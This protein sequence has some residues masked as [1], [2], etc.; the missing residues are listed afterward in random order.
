M[1]SAFVYTVPINITVTAPAGPSLTGPTQETWV[2]LQGSSLVP[3]DTHTVTLTNGGGSTAYVKTVTVTGDFDVAG[4]ATG[5]TVDPSGGTAT[6]TVTP[7]AS[8]L[9]TINTYTGSV[10]IVY[11]D[12]A[13][14][15]DK[16]LT[17]GLRAEVKNATLPKIVSAETSGSFTMGGT[18]NLTKLLT[19][20]STAIQG[21]FNGVTTIDWYKGDPANGGTLVGTT[22]KTTSI[23]FL[24]SGGWAIGDEVYI[25]VMGDGT[26]YDAAPVDIKVGTIEQ[27]AVDKYTIVVQKTDTNGVAINDNAITAVAAPT[28]LGPNDTANLFTN[29]TDPGYKFVKWVIAN[30]GAGTLTNATTANSATYKAPATTGTATITIQAQYSLMPVLEVK[31]DVPTT[32]GS[33][34]SG[35]AT[36]TGKGSAT[37][38]TGTLK[39]AATDSGHAANFEVTVGGAASTTIAAGSIGNTAK[40]EVKVKSGVTLVPGQTYDMVLTVVDDEGDK[41]E[42]NVTYTAPYPKWTITLKHNEHGTL[43][44]NFG[45]VSVATVITGSADA[46]LNNVSHGGTVAIE[47]APAPGYKFAGWTSSVTAGAGTPATDAFGD[48]TKAATSYAN[49]TQAAT[50]TATFKPVTDLSLDPT[51]GVGTLAEGYTS[52]SAIYTGTVTNA[53]AKASDV[54]YALFK[55]AGCTQADTSNNFVL[56]SAS[57]TIAAAGTNPGTGT[58]TVTPKASGLTAGTYKTYL[59]IKQGEAVGDTMSGVKTFVVPITLYVTTSS[60]F[61]GTVTVKVDDTVKNGVA[62][63]KLTADGATIAPVTVSATGVASFAGLDINKSY[64]VAV[65]LDGIDANYKD[66]GKTVSNGA[67]TATV[68]YYTLTLSAGTG[69]KAVSYAANPTTSDSTLTKVV[70]KGTAVP[71]YAAASAGYDPSSLAWT[72]TKTTGSGAVASTELNSMVT[73]K[74]AVTATADYTVGNGVKYMMNAGDATAV[75]VTDNAYYGASAN[76]TLPAKPSR[77]GYT[78]KGWATTAAGTAIANSATATTLSTANM[79]AAASGFYTLYAVWE[80]ATA[81]WNTLGSGV[82]GAEYTGSASIVNGAAV[83]AVAY[84]VSTGTD[85]TGLPDG[86]TFTAATGAIAGTPK[87]T[88]TFTFTVTATSTVNSSD[89]WEKADYE[90]VVAKATPTVT[91]LS[92]AGVDEGVA[93]ADVTVYATVTAPYWNPTGGT[94]TGAWET[95]KQYVYSAS[96]DPTLNPGAL[97]VESP[98]TLNFAGAT[99]LAGTVKFTAATGT[100]TALMGTHQ[101]AQKF[102]D[103]YGDVTVPCVFSLAGKTYGITVDPASKSADINVNAAMP[104][105]PWAFKVTNMG[106]QK[107]YVTYKLDNSADAAKFTLTPGYSNTNHDQIN[108]A[109]A[110]GGTEMA[111]AFTLLPVAYNASSAPNGI[112]PAVPGVYTVNVI[113]ENHEWDTADGG[114]LG[115]VQSTVTVPVRFE[116]KAPDYVG[117]ITTHLNNVDGSTTANGQVPG[118]NSLTLTEVGGTATVSAAWDGTSYKTA[119]DALTGGKSYTVAIGGYVVPGVYLSNANPSAT[120]E[121]YEVKLVNA[122]AANTGTVTL[123]GPGY[124][125]A[126]QT[127]TVSAPA[128]ATNATTSKNYDFVDWKKDA[129]TTNAHTTYREFSYQMPATGATDPAPAAVTFTAAYKERSALTVKVTYEDN[130]PDGVILVP[131]TKDDVAKGGTT[132]LAATAPVRPGYDF[133]G[134]STAADA[135]KADFNPDTHTNP[136]TGAGNRYDALPGATTPALDNDVTL[137]A[138]WEKQTA[139]WPDAALANGV[140]GSQYGASVAVTGGLNVNV[141]YALKMGSGDLP[142]GLKLSSDGVI[143][144]KPYEV[145]ANRSFTVV[146]TQTGLIT[147]VDGASTTNTWEKEFTITVEQAQPHLS[148]IAT[149]GTAVTGAAYSTITY[150]ADVVAPI[151]QTKESDPTVPADVWETR[152]VATVKAAPLP[153]DTTAAADGGVL[154]VDTPNSTFVGT[155]INPVPLTWTPGAS[156]GAYPLNDAHGNNFGTIYKAA[157]DTA[158]VSTNGDAYAMTVDPVSHSWTVEVGYANGSYTASGDGNPVH[159]GDVDGNTAYGKQFTLTNTGNQPTGALQYKFGTAGSSNAAGKYFAMDL[160]WVTNN[161]SLPVNA[162]TV[163]NTDHQRKFSVQPRVYT[164]DDALTPG[165]YT[166]TLTISSANG[167]SAVVYSLTLVVKE[168]STFDM[169]VDTKLHTADDR[170]GA[171]GDVTSIALRAV[172]TTDDT[173]PDTD[174]AHAANSGKYAWTGLDSTKTYAVVV[175]GYVSNQIVTAATTGP[176][177]VDL[178]QMTLAQAP[179]GAGSTLKL[180]DVAVTSGY[181]LAGQPLKASATVPTGKS[182]EDWDLSV[183]SDATGSVDTEGYSTSKALTYVMPAAPAKLTANFTDVVEYE[184]QVVDADGTVTYFN[185]GTAE[186]YLDILTGGTVKDGT[187]YMVSEGAAFGL[188]QPT[189]GTLATGQYSVTKVGYTFRGWSTDAAA[190]TGAYVFTA[191]AAADTA[192]GNTADKVIQ[193]YPVWTADSDLAFTGGTVTG[194]Y[195]HALTNQKVTPATGGSAPYAYDWND[196]TTDGTTYRPFGVTMNAAGDFASTADATPNGVGS[197]TV[198]IKAADAAGDTA[199]ADYVFIISKAEMEPDATHGLP[200]AAVA[201]TMGDTLDTVKTAILGAITAASTVMNGDGTGETAING[202]WTVDPAWVLPTE[203]GTYDVPVIYTPAND[204]VGDHAHDGDNYNPYHGTVKVTLA[205]KAITGVDMQVNTPQT[206]GTPDSLSTVVTAMG[207][208]TNHVTSSDN[209]AKWQT[210]LEVKAVRWAPTVATTFE[211]NTRYTVTVDLAIKDGSKYRFDTSTVTGGAY[212]FTAQVNGQTATL[213]SINANTVSLSYEFPAEAKAIQ[214][215]DVTVGTLGEGGTDTDVASAKPSQ[216]TVTGHKWYDSDGTLVSNDNKFNTS[217]TYDLVVTVK[218]EEGYQ[219]DATRFGGIVSTELKDGATWYATVN[220]VSSGTDPAPKTAKVEVALT[221]D[222]VLQIRYSAFTPVAETPLSI[223]SVTGSVGAYYAMTGADAASHKHYDA[224]A[225]GNKSGVG[226]TFNPAGVTVKVTFQKADGSTS[227]KQV[228]VGDCAFYAGDPDVSG[229]TAVKLIDKTTAAHVFKNFG[230]DTDVEKYDGQMVY[231]KYGTLPA[232]QV[233]T[234]SVRALEVMSIDKGTD[235]MPKL[236]YK[237]GDHFDPATTHTAPAKVSFNTNLPAL[238]NQN[239]ELSDNYAVKDTTDN[240]PLNYY[241]ATGADGSGEL[242][243][244]TVLAAGDNGKTVYLCYTDVNDNTV[245]VSVGTLKVKA[246]FAVTVEDANKGDPEYNDTLTAVPGTGIPDDYNYRWEKWNPTGGTGGSGAWEPITGATGQTYVPGKTDIGKV[247]RVTATDKTTGTSYSSATD[248]TDGLTIMARS[249]NFKV[250]AKDKVVDGDA[251]NKYTYLATD[252]TLTNVPAA[253]PNPAFGGIV[254][255]DV[256]S[257]APSATGWNTADAT[258]PDYGAATVG[259][260]ITWPAVAV[261][262]GTTANKTGGYTLT[263]T[264]KD[265]YRLAAQ[266]AQ[267]NVGEILAKDIINV[268]HVDVSFKAIP[269]TGA[270]IPGSPMGVTDLRE[271]QDGDPTPGA[272][273]NPT[274]FKAYWYE[275]AFNVDSIASYTPATGTFGPGKTYTVAVYVKPQTGYAYKYDVSASPAADRTQFNFHFGEDQHVDATN[276]VKKVDPAGYYIMYHTFTTPTANPAVSLGGITKLTTQLYYGSTSGKHDADKRVAGTIPGDQATVPFNFSTAGLAGTVTLADGSTKTLNLAATDDH[277]DGTLEYSTDWSLV[278]G[279]SAATATQALANGF[280]FTAADMAKYDGKKV[281]VKVGDVVLDTLTTGGDASVGTLA[282]KEL[283]AESITPVYEA[284]KGANDVLKYTAGSGFNASAI[285]DATV[286]FNQGTTGLSGT[287]TAAEQANAAD[288]AGAKYYFEVNAGTA[289]KNGDQ[290]GGTTGTPVAKDGDVLYLCYTD[291]NGHEV[292]IA[293]GTIRTTDATTASVTIMNVTTTVGNATT[294]SYGDQLQAV[295]GGSTTGK[296]SY[297]WQ[298]W[299]AGNNKWVDIPN[300]NGN[301]YTAGKDDVD[302]AAALDK[303][304]RVV[305]TEAGKEGSAASSNDALTAG[306]PAAQTTSGVDVTP[307]ALTVT[308][309]ADDKVYDGTTAATI[310]QGNLVGV[311]SGDT[312]SIDTAEGK[313]VTGTFTQKGSEGAEGVAAGKTVT[314]TTATLTGADKDYYKLTVPANPTADITA[315][316][317][318]WGDLAFN[319]GTEKRYDAT[320]DVYTKDNAGNADNLNNPSGNAKVAAGQ[321]INATAGTTDAVEWASG[322]ALTAAQKTALESS[323]LKFNFAYASKNA[324]GDEASKILVKAVSTGVSTANFDLSALASDDTIYGCTVNP[325]QFNVA[326]ADLKTPTATKDGSPYVTIDSNELAPSDARIENGEASGFKFKFTVQGEFASTAASGSAAVTVTGVSAGSS[327]GITWTDRNYEPLWDGNNAT[328]GTVTGG[329]VTKVALDGTPSVIYGDAYSTAT[330]LK[331]NV[332]YDGASEVGTTL[333]SFDALVNLGVKAVV[334]HNTAHTGTAYAFVT[335]SRLA[336]WM[337]D[338]AASGDT[339][340]LKFYKMTGADDA[341]DAATAWT[342][343]TIG[344]GDTTDDA[345]KGK[346]LAV[347][348]ITVKPRELVAVPVWNLAANSNTGKYYDGTANALG[349]VWDVEADSKTATGSISF[350][351]DTILNSDAVNV[352]SGY[353]ATFADKNAGENKTITIGNTPVLE[354]AQ[355]KRYILTM[356][357]ATGSI[358]PRPITVAFDAP[359]VPLDSMDAAASKTVNLSKTFDPTVTGVTDESIAVSATGTYDTVATP[360]VAGAGDNTAADGVGNVAVTAPIWKNANYNVTVQT[361]INGSVTAKSIANVAITYNQPVK[362]GKTTDDGTSNTTNYKTPVTFSNAAQVDVTATA[363]HT[364]ASLTDLSTATAVTNDAFTAGGYYMVT[365]TVTAKAGYNFASD[366]AFTV[367]DATKTLGT[368]DGVAPTNM[369]VSVSSDKLTA[370]VKYIFAVPADSK[371]IAHVVADIPLPTVGNTV[372]SSKTS[373]TTSILTDENLSVPAATALAVEDP[374]ITWNV[375]GNDNTWG[376]VTSDKFESGKAY[377]AVLTYTVNTGD[378]YTFASAADFI[379]KGVGPALGGGSVGTAGTPVTVNGVTVTAKETTD[380]QAYVLTVEFP[381]T[382]S[383]NVTNVIINTAPLPPVAGEI[384]PTPYVVGSE[385]YQDS[386]ST[387]KWQKSSDNISWS[388]LPVGETEFKANTYYQIVG[389]VKLK[390]GEVDNYDITSATKFFIGTLGS[391][392]IG[393]NADTLSALETNGYG[394]K[395]EHIAGT[396]LDGV[397]SDDSTYTLTLRYNKLEDNTDK[398]IVKIAANVA[399]PTSNDQ[400]PNDANADKAVLLLAQNKDGLD[401]TAGVKK[402]DIEW[403]LGTEPGDA[404]GAAAASTSSDFTGWTWTKLNVGADFEPGKTYKVKFNVSADTD[405]GYKLLADESSDK[406]VEYLINSILN[407]SNQWFNGEDMGKLGRITAATAVPAASADDKQSYDV[408]VYFENVQ[409]SADVFSVWGKVTEP[410]NGVTAAD[411]QIN[412]IN[413]EEPYTL[414]SGSNKWYNDADCTDATTGTFE[415]GKTYYATLQ[416]KAKNHYQFLHGDEG[417]DTKGYTNDTAAGATTVTYVQGAGTETNPEFIT[418]VRPFTVP[419]IPVNVRVSSTVPTDGAEVAT[420]NA[421]VKAPTGVTEYAVSAGKWYN[422][423]GTTEATSFEAGKTYKLIAK[424]APTDD[425][426]ALNADRGG[427]S[428]DEGYRIANTVESSTPAGVYITT[429]EYT[430]PSAGKVVPSTYVKAPAKGQKGTEAVGTNVEIVDTTWSGNGQTNVQPDAITFQDGKTYTVNVTIKGED[431][432]G[433]PISAGSVVQINGRDVTITSGMSDG[434]GNWIITDSWSLPKEGDIINGGSGGGGGGGGGGSSSEIVVT[435]WL[436]ETGVTKDLTAEAVKKNKYPTNVPSVTG[437]S[438]YKFLGW[439]ETDPAK[440]SGKPK[441]VDPTSFKI[442]GDKT[443]YAVYETEAGHT[444]IDHGH[445]VIGYPNGTF[446]PS[447]DITRGSVATIIARACLEGFVEGSDYGNPGNYSDV[448]NDWAYS[449]ISFC[450]INGVFKGYDDGTFR[451]GQPITRQEFAT[452]IARLA[453]IQSNQGMP[454]SDAGDIASW[455]VDGVYTTYANGWVNGYTDGTFKPL[456]NIH[457]DEAVKIFNGYLNRGVDAAG[458]SGLTEYV[459]SGVASHN[460]EDGSTQY[461]TWPDVPKGH[462][463]YYE[464]IE[465]A[466]DHT[467]YWPDETKPVP[468]EHWMNVWINEVW[469]YHDNASDG[470][471]TA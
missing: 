410:R 395:F 322:S 379:I 403:Y 425:K 139:A 408:S 121:M 362:G 262:A 51:S 230:T 387:I 266:G 84:A 96:G 17:I 104:T 187:K 249:L 95:A 13:T 129:E 427:Y 302:T 107:A 233:G 40:V 342:K 20:T 114:K 323:G 336:D 344:A 350:S 335:G 132:Q 397:Y 315:L 257:M 207:N 144:G 371:V 246:T 307:K 215:I 181:Y 213:N 128:D 284:G 206:G 200:T 340:N 89:T 115:G 50:L 448:A 368:A 439:S 53:G 125:A 202:G 21:A 218:P 44:A 55:D 239:V 380:N 154:A 434:H 112:N 117:A 346:N 384:I 317:L 365:A 63:V 300:A 414:V 343:S 375:K 87:E 253:A 165:V 430:I 183:Y 391:V 264:D 328:T 361:P 194:V 178:Y 157:K 238:S 306:T 254:P 217:K 2:K 419:K 168:A 42:L 99:T 363:W 369:S 429:F 456:S 424:A 383:Q 370:T 296:L 69:A 134:W 447:D 232:T 268:S 313:K 435:Y 466:N 345:T 60:T 119:A 203:P 186:S 123:T 255:G 292:R 58:V 407:N 4:I 241:F 91:A 3:G 224:A 22:G 196:K 273:G 174:P 210:D 66:T 386:G 464:I 303:N 86:L 469:R 251:L 7:K 133:V 195:K 405:N 399:Q 440:T 141:T 357:T 329:A 43:S 1:A 48:D 41:V 197:K 327:A 73:V 404:T 398:T 160:G 396:L 36:N 252:F 269:V 382:G 171:L 5:A 35:T 135:T 314:L 59:Q 312:V 243:A 85:Q 52:P 320:T 190:A 199:V 242:T 16:T 348:T 65:S 319:V 275:G 423:D 360:I 454:F 173:L 308:Y 441:L 88:G 325:K 289:I 236:E 208:G 32:T 274:T 34:W 389:T 209:A 108:P 151:L 122:S 70:L 45:G 281:F 153:A 159:D 49:V 101:S 278:V 214:V 374:V 54:T 450:T 81:T 373:A 460:T 75:Y 445:Y 390:N 235:N 152:V 287:Y 33:A 68:D 184:V 457:R 24:S 146:A 415:A 10:K 351:Y 420:I 116:V 8:I 290:I 170:A 150:T 229:S 109:T 366:A 166:D 444:A 38:V 138:V 334:E 227:I 19:D 418:L 413:D 295:V 324:L 78:F 277:D 468:P 57:A 127:G 156:T 179:A 176:V 436:G 392:E 26:A 231:V 417:F 449:A 9:S 378:G 332:Y 28:A 400:V 177:V 137:Y 276:T 310:H 286:S 120:V 443:F 113:V 163:G 100:A 149:S 416:V 271:T 23:S 261:D 188:P 67:K 294:A 90:I 331:I 259:S 39:D 354:G 426:Y 283:T 299:D 145:A 301:F 367:N 198:K 337:N 106:N 248:G 98:S 240:T 377:Q 124:L 97:T 225:T 102:S 326:V 279:D 438:G 167:A 30:S 333:T 80:K 455:A 446:G 162:N 76:V 25:R 381:K 83:G 103:I 318:T 280:T 388:D 31:K 46:T 47:A 147:A 142:G 155:G 285:T 212:A 94:G 189:T 37:N 462:W 372:N 247:I 356:E 140:Y 14:G 305:V 311:I 270:A 143:T 355:A 459:H 393:Q 353:T 433:N 358:K 79:G 193:L 82:Y 172:G 148:N 221:A 338:A 29:T 131:P 470:G 267:A 288:A 432:T 164:G 442:T 222:G 6:F 341:T 180:D 192:D 352:K 304:L 256:V 245:S 228:A 359:T 411:N 219:F 216:Y 258:R 437:I 223:A 394:V 64:A 77:S 185:G 458:L 309:T 244:A 467:F 297:Q 18:V 316:K 61:T 451:P 105:T 136:A 347:G 191:N 92:F 265:C 321:T 298:R 471:P 250:A 110:S 15:G 161:N 422:A 385:P 111:D 62:K 12:G 263:G 182:L 130:Y 401:M 27:P 421:S 260:A 126:G 72:L 169:E 272:D 428:W 291:V 282:V 461:M 376:A 11:N 93:K 226:F 402:K 453:G 118:V 452:V 74:E 158:N 406:F 293:I 237:V 339:L 409:E 234:L 71:V 204:V 205:A 463:A 56:S 412:I 431:L 364:A 220:G 211:A 175:N 349:T 465:A 330:G 201:A